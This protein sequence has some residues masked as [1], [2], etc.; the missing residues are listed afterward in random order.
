MASVSLDV[1]TSCLAGPQPLSVSYFSIYLYGLSV[2]ERS[3]FINFDP[4]VSEPAAGISNLP[5]EGPLQSYS[6][7]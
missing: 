6:E 4:D 5:R 1:G 2:P 7:S 3:E